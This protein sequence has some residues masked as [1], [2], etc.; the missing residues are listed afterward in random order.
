MSTVDPIGTHCTGPSPVT[1]H[2][3]LQ[4]CG[5]ERLVTQPR[6]LDF[7]LPSSH[8]AQVSMIALETAMT[9]TTNQQHV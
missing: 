4:Y 2:A 9:T 3:P 1:V 5:G 8:A 7:L 6:A